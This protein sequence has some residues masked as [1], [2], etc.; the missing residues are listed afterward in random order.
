MGLTLQSGFSLVTV[1]LLLILGFLF[2]TGPTSTHAVARTALASGYRP[3]LVD[4]PK[5][6]GKSA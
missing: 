2:F 6:G 4:E 5:A 1:K 3:K